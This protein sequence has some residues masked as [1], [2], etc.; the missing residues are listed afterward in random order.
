[1]RDTFGEA[2]A[3]VKQCAT[4][5]ALGPGAQQGSHDR[6]EVTLLI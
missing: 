4:P 3:G 1:M 6:C 5:P 2:S